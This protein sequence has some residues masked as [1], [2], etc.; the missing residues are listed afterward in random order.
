MISITLPADS[1]LIDPIANTL[2][3]AMA[4]APGDPN[5]YAS[6]ISRCFT[7]LVS[8]LLSAILCAAL[9]SI[10]NHNGP[11]IPMISP[12]LNDHIPSCM[13]SLAPIN[14]DSADECAGVLCLQH[15]QW[16][17]DPPR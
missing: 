2:P 17:H 6:R 10:C 5:A 9:L 15:V 14:S 7:L 13:T 4:N 12:S 1:L 8:P 3:H 16:M 11:F